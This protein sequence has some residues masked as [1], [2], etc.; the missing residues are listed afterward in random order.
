MPGKTVRLFGFLKSKRFYGIV[1]TLIGLFVVLNYIVLPIYV[2]HGSTL[3]VPRVIGLS[4]EMA[5]AA[6][7]SAGLQAVEADTRPDPVQPPGTVV[8]QNPSPQAI[9]KHGRH[10]YLTV[11]GGDVLVSV[12]LLRGRSSRDA[13]FSLE[14]AG[15]KLGS[16]SYAVSD[17]Y[18]ENTIIDQSTNPETKVPRGASVDIV[19]SRGNVVEETVVPSLIGKTTTEAGK[20]LEIAGLK[21]GNITFQPSFDLLPNTVVDQYPRSGE[22]AKR[23]QSVDLFVVQVGK[24]TEEIQSHKK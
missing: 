6:L 5:K 7:D 13:K 14:R 11:S 10:V 3:Y 2:N 9:V 24:P 15:L 4:V 16:T 8:Y 1:G 23:G 18:P 19:V 17:A 20:L 12:P 21:L 22:P